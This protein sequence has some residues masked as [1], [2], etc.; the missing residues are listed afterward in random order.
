VMNL[1]KIGWI[2]DLAVGRDLADHTELP[3]WG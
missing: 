1:L 2:A 3:E